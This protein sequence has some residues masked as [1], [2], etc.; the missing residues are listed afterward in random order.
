MSQRDE[1]RDHDIYIIPHNFIEGGKVFGGMFRMRN[2]VEAG[3]LALATGYPIL[4]LSMGLYGRIVLLCVIT[5]PLVLFAMIGIGDNSLSEFVINFFVFLRKRRVLGEDPDMPVEEDLSKAKKVFRRFGNLFKR[6]MP[7]RKVEVNPDDFE[8]VYYDSEDEI[9]D[10]AAGWESFQNP[11]KPSD[12][13]KEKKKTG[14]GKKGGKGRKKPPRVK[15]EDATTLEDYLPIDNVEN[16]ILKTKDGRYIKILEIEP[17]NFLLR[18]PREQ[19]NIIFSFASLLKITPIRLQFKVISRKA[20]VNQHLQKI[21]EYMATE[22]DARCRELQKDYFNLIRRV[23][24]REAVTRRFFMVFEYQSPLATRRVEYKEIIAMLETTARNARSYL[25]QCGNDVVEHDNEDEFISEVFY[26]L[27][28][29]RS[30]VNITLQDRVASTIAK[31]ITSTDDKQLDDISANELVK[32]LAID[33]THSRYLV[34]DGLYYSYLI[35]PSDSYKMQVVAGW[36]SLIINAGEGIDVDI[37][38]YKEPKERVQ[39]KIGQQIRINRSKIK[40]TSD[41][42]TDFDDLSGAIQSGYF[43]KRGISNNEDFYYLSILITITA[44]NVRDLEWRISEMK[45][46]L[47]SQDMD[48]KVCSFQQEQAFLSSL[49]IVSMDKKLF[50]KAKRNLL[51]TGAASCYPFTSFEMSDDSGI[52]MGVNKHNNSLVIVD[53]FNS[54]LYKNA[55]MAILGTSGGATRCRDDKSAA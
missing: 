5:L 25:R 54:R 17:I 51:T 47:I 4:K 37:F 43:L 40:D 28:N 31:Y 45:K 33:F 10:D 50:D 49:P 44:G 18:S 41:T 38:F 32:P 39:Q 26:T 27:L 8:I 6:K 48:A 36:L 42:N 3:V 14:R 34:M 35:I 15:P 30:A 46:L 9:P 16:G 55:N 11:E 7:A 19:R 29:R 12:S 53:I 1:E 2:A 21:R 13:A 24:S 23:G 20:D 22:K 52:L